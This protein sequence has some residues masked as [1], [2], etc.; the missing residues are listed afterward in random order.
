MFL[1]NNLD[2][3]YANEMQNNVS[4]DEITRTNSQIYVVMLI[5]VITN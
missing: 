5:C 3:F 4:Y 1:K 2:L